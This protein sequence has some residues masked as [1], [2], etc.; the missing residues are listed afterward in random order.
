[1]EYKPNRPYDEYAMNENADTLVTAGGEI[2]KTLWSRRAFE[3]NGEFEIT[4]DTYRDDMVA[5]YRQCRGPFVWI[6]NPNT[7]PNSYHLMIREGGFELPQIEANLRRTTLIATEQ[8]P[9]QY[10]LD[11][12]ENG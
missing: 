4:S 9:E 11:V 5:F 12:A 3:L 8:G 6:E 2:H 7:S 10:Y 1:M